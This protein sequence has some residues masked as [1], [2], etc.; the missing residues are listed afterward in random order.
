MLKS[1]FFLEN[2]R[3]YKN[4]ENKKESESLLIY[5]TEIFP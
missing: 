4:E 3:T 2:S 1:A 5:Q